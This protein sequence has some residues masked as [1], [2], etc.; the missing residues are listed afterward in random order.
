MRLEGLTL[1]ERG[2]ALRLDST[3]ATLTGETF[4]PQRTLTV[5]VKKCHSGSLEV[6]CSI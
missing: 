4:L 1:D 3:S 6:G 2:E 5:R